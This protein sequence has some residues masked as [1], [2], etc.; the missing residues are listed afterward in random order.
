MGKI[1]VIKTVMR[2]SK[3]KKTS[4]KKKKSKYQIY[5]CEKKKTQVKSTG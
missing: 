3:M 5:S 2:N 4:K 1:G